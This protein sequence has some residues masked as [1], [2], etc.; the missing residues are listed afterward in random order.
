MH[1]CVELERNH[2]LKVTL[3]LSA[4]VVDCGIPQS[5]PNGT[6]TLVNGS[7]TL[8][9]TVKYE[10]RMGF[11]LVGSA[12]RI[13]QSDGQWNGQEPMCES[14]LCFERTGCNAQ[15]TKFRFHKFC[16][17]SSSAFTISFSP[18]NYTILEG[19]PVNLMIVLDKPSSKNITITVS[20]MDITASG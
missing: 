8:N 12:N 2:F 3:Y 16:N 19:T 11:Q 5:F 7:T 9:S 17:C 10:C 18:Q 6:I 20:T 14:K 13:C 4:A 1:M 15:C